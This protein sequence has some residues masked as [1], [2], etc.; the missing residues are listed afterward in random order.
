MQAIRWRK[1]LKQRG[2]NGSQE[3]FELIGVGSQIA[4]EAG[5]LRRNF[6][7]ELPDAVIAATAIP[8]SAKL[9][10]R[11]KGHFEMISNFNMIV[12]Y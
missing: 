1:S 12:P 3:M 5:K 11:N 2:Q 9:V 8:F 10:T 6:G 4:R 7:C